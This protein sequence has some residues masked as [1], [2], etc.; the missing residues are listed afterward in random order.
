[1]M[2][3]IYRLARWLY[4]RGVPVLPWVLKSINRIAFGVVL[5]PSTRV[6]QGVLLSYEG[7]GTVIHK[8]AVIGDGAVIASGVTIGGRSGKEGV[9]EIGEGALI[10]TGAKV[11]GP[12]KVGRYA[13]VGAN[14]VVLSDVPDFGIAVGV[15][16]RLI[17]VAAPEAS[18][19]SCLSDE[20]VIRL[21]Y[22]R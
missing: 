20:N 4:C 16:A 18:L 13:S 22:D 14:A 1:M 9:P 17:R 15:P 7:L 2:I 6:G 11:L 21:H 8:R 3:R 10:G 5:P 19:T 12:V